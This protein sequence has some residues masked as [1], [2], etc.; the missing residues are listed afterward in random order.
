MLST[1]N[2]TPKAAESIGFESVAIPPGV[3]NFL[4]APSP[5]DSAVLL[6]TFSADPEAHFAPAPAPNVRN[7]SLLAAN[8]V[9]EEP[10]YGGEPLNGIDLSSIDTLWNDI[11]LFGE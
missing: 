9:C 6:N 7:S 5:W 1:D 8:V 11:A 4:T 10:Q 3:E 2:L